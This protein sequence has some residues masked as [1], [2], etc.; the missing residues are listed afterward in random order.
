M[1]LPGLTK[2]IVIIK[3]C[4]I[5]DIMIYLSIYGTY[6][7]KTNIECCF[8]S[9]SIDICQLKKHIKLAS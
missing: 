4:H 9:L 5:K 1:V 2:D 7:N 8:D 3:C 6:N